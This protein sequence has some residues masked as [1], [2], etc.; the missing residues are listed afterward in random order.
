MMDREKVKE[1]LIEYAKDLDNNRKLDS[2][3]EGLERVCATEQIAS[4]IIA[5][6]EEEKPNLPRPE[7]PH[8]QYIM[9][10]G[11]QE[12]IS[13]NYKTFEDGVKATQKAFIAAGWRPV[14]SEIDDVL[15]ERQRQDDKWG[16][17]DHTPIEWLPIL[18]EEV[19]EVSKAICESYFDDGGDYH[20]GNYY[21][22]LTQVTAV[23]LAMME[24]YNRTC[25]RTP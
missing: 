24:C 6:F 1:I 7:N 18:V 14:P 25:P 20:G 2:L 11:R 9:I 4:R 16:V 23:G 21:E 17:Q 3:G 15:K 8:P 10:G 13:H 22:E 19:G 12:V 5:L